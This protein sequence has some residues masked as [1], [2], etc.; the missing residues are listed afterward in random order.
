[1]N[2]KPG[3]LKYERM[4]PTYR[5]TEARLADYRAVEQRLTDSEIQIQ[6]ARCMDCGTPF[7]HG[8]GCPLCNV[9]P[10][11]NRCIVK[12]RWRTAL[13][14][15]LSTNCMPEFTARVCPALCEGSCVLG[16][17]DGPVSIRQIELA[18]IERGF[19]EEYIAPR[20]P[21][22]RRQKKV[23]VVGSGPAGLAAAILLNRAGYEVVVFE[24]ANNPGGILRYGIPDF[25]LE[26][27]ILKRRIELMQQEG[28]V[29]ET[30][31]QIGRDVSLRYLKSRF[32]AGV[33]ACGAQ[34]PRDLKVPGRELEGIHFAM[35]YLVQQNKRI[36]GEFIAPNEE[37]LAK[38]KNVVIIG[39][40]DTGSDC[41]GTAL[42]QGA[43]RVV[44]LE[45]LP[46][47]PEA[48]SADNP[49]P[50]WPK[51]LRES[52]SHKEGGERR[53]SVAT[54]RFSGD[55]RGHVKKLHC[56]EVEWTAGND[57]V[58]PSCKNIA[59]TEFTL[60]VDLV[61]LAAGFVGPKKNPL[62]DELSLELDGRGMI[63]GDKNHMTSARSFFVAG[64]MR[65]G[66][67]LVVHAI[68]DGQ[69]AAKGVIRF[70]QNRSA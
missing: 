66:P 19:S 24:N 27:G 1:M 54:E 9:I 2:A 47:P 63:L 13:D 52:S 36:G 49:W 8:T 64:D 23:A 34:N 37:I 50:A 59:G 28:V 17:D 51:T 31:V 25:K 65:L 68:A 39:G 32:S 55:E 44:Q 43:K 53:W 41:L 22:T 6:A 57:D 38:D 46:R 58:P 35:E 42:R 67:S 30:G 20:P 40:G 45:I 14:I 69:R 4:V 29:F 3:F 62:G 18:I 11:F 26:K 48:R 60:D 7:C 16:I 12:G 61:L 10:E 33:F 5:P 56:V 21:K 70:L 15:L